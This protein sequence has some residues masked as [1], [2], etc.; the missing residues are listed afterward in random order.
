MNKEI[1]EAMEQFAQRVLKGEAEPQE[2]AIL[3]EVL[4]MLEKDTP[5]KRNMERRV[6]EQ[7]ESHQVQPLIHSIE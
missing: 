5:A 3:P 4:K 2:T 7:Q 1:V 6:N